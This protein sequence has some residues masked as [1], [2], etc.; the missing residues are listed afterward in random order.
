MSEPSQV[1]VLGPE[2]RDEAVEVLCTA[3]SNYP[4]FRFALQDAGANYARGLEALIGHFTD[5]RL[6]TGCPVL[7]DANVAFDCRVGSL[8]EQGSH[9]VMWPP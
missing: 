2:Q 4:V 9:S 7:T 5:T 6:A 8:I 1:E 3:F